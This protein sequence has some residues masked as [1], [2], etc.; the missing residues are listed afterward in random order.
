MTRLL[1]PRRWLARRRSREAE[2]REEL[3][4]HIQQEI[5]EGLAAGLNEANARR[6]ARRELG[7]LTV[8]E[9]DTRAAWGWSWLERLGQDVRY[10]GRLLRRRP[11]FS[12]AAV[13]TLAL[14]MGGA[15]AVFSLV[16]A[17]LLRHLPVDRP[18]QLV[19]L[20]EYRPDRAAP[21]E[22]FTVATHDRL[23]PSMRTLS[24]LAGSTDSRGPTSIEINGERATAVVQ[25]VS[26][27]YFEVL[28]VPAFKGRV[29]R[30]PGPGLNEEPIAVISADYWRSRYAASPSALGARFRRGGREFTIVGVA[31]PGFRGTDIDV[32]ADIWIPIEQV[33]PRT[34]EDR[35][36]GRW[37]RI[38]GRLAPGTNRKQASRESAALVGRPVEFASGAVGYS[39]L[40]HRLARPLALVA[41]VVA[42]VLLIAC[43]NL[44][45]LMLAG[46]KSRERELAVRTAIGASRS[47]V[48]RQLLTEGLVLAVA[49]GALAPGVASWISGALL[50]FLPPGDALALAN[51]RFDLDG[52]VLGFAALLTCGACLLFALAP[53]LRVTAGLGGAPDLRTRPGGER[54]RSWASRGALVGQIVMCTALLVIAGVFLRTLQN[55]RGQDAGYREEGL[56]VADVQPPADSDDRR[57]QYIE[58][59]LARIAALPGVAIAAFSHIGQLDGAIEFRIGFPGHDTPK[60][61]LPLMIEQRISPGFLQAMGNP[62]IAGRDFAWSDDV[63]AP[64]VAI[65]NESFAR[66]FFPGQDPLGGRF[67]RASGTFGGEPMTIVG[68]VRDS[69][70]ENLR[71]DPSPMYYRPYRQMGGTPVVRFAIRSSGDLNVLAGQLR[72]IARSIDPAFVLTNVVPFREIVD[73]T[74]V[75]ERLVAQVSTAFGLLALSIAAVGLYGV[76]AYSVARRRRE[77]GVRMAVGA[78]PHAIAWM[79]LRESLV[80]LVVGLALGLPLALVITRLV[81]SMLFGLGPHDP[82]SIG[83][84]LGVLTAATLAA[85]W[86]PARRAATIDPIG[87]LRDD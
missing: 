38:M 11:V 66:R 62:V 33:V 14:G 80:L 65:V 59:L 54:A 75:I 76:Q 20:I 78:R 46:M 45:N 53:A 58:A 41:F 18:E 36:R 74:L 40:R 68:V 6:A 61:D 31:A 27:N 70:W 9:E 56:L 49:G 42:L 24:G 63:H 47:R 83:V 21:L 55:L 60:D 71:H 35:S 84:A 1:N 87:A 23:R 4:F 30:A 69:R 15:T 3:E 81:S 26:D 5:E 34:D 16:H 37:M 44:A 43:A 39:T 57:D 72:P 85:A 17:L 12:L 73:R 77:I 29:F 7:S 50:A 22:T 10:A 52:R 82:A 25:L 32:P 8:I 64:L 2:I 48:V 19:R 28:G 51:L 67:Y 86:L 79:F 13:I